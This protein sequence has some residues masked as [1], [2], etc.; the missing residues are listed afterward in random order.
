M[1]GGIY[2]SAVYLWFNECGLVAEY[3]ILFCW[4][5]G[6]WLGEVLIP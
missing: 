3:L 1:C 5:A 4:L 6:K 2:D